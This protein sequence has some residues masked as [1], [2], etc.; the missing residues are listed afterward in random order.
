[1]YKPHNGA[2]PARSRHALAWLGTEP[3]FAQLRERTR[4]L[5][6]LQQELCRCV[7]GVRLDAVSLENGVL[8]VGAAQASAAAKIRQ[9]GPSILAELNRCGW[10]VERIR[11][12]PLMAPARAAERQAKVP[13]SERAAASVAALSESVDDPRLREALRRLARRHGAA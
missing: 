4:R 8:V 9:F 10:K 11:F 13:L 1:M 3:G 6:A 2:K 5:E 7:P 12:K